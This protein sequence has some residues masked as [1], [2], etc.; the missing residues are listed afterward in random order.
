MV[1]F[2]IT[3]WRKKLVALIVGLV[4]FVTLGLGINWI[5]SPEDSAVVA[6]EDKLQDDVMTQPVKVQGQPSQNTPEVTKPEAEDL[7]GK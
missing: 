5:L 7:K 2:T 6:P 4:F 3:K 1:I